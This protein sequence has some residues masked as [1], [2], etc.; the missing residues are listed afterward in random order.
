MGEKKNPGKCE[1]KYKLVG[2][3]FGLSVLLGWIITGI[4]ISMGAPFWFD[5]LNKL[6]KLKGSGG[7]SNKNSE[8]S[9]GS[10][11]TVI[12]PKG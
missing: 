10:N 8:K 7:S 3:P 1:F 6:M 4:A 12:Q 5:L 2:K 9:G 11:Q